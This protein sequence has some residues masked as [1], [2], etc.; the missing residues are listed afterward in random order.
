[1]SGAPPEKGPPPDW[2]VLVSQ[3]LEAAVHQTLH[4]RSIYPAAL[5]VRTKLFGVS[6]QM[7]RH[8][9][10]NHYVHRAVD[11]ARRWLEAGELE[12]LAVV[13][14]SPRSGPLERV[15]FEFPRLPLPSEQEPMTE[16]GGATDRLRGS[17]ASFLLKTSMLN[18]SLGAANFGDDVTFS[19]ALRTR[20]AQGEKVIR[21]L[22]H[23]SGTRLSKHGFRHKFATNGYIEYYDVK[24][25]YIV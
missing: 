4:V 24:S 14:R 18:T 9:E 1:M 20:T 25:N 17:L 22:V 15:L 5:F 13:I 7:S 3:F 12:A 23:P 21:Y 11:G 8:P 2:V 10:L 19:I 6:V 16:E